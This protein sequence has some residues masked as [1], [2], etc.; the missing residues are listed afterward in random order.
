MRDYRWA[1]FSNIINSS[2]RIFFFFCFSTLWLCTFTCKEQ[3]ISSTNLKERKIVLGDLFCTSPTSEL[4]IN[5][6]LFKKPESVA[7]IWI[8]IK[9][10]HNMHSSFNYRYLLLERKNLYGFKG[11][12]KH[13]LP[14]HAV[15]S[16]MEAPLFCEAIVLERLLWRHF[17]L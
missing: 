12:D 17:T 1:K 10:F 8:C 3:T 16:R 7:L 5:Y 14:G 13:W 15:I 6:C 11:N 9:M 4:E 2:M